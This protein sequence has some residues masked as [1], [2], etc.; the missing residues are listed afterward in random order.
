MKKVK[1]FEAHDNYVLQ[2]SFTS[3]S[4]RLISAGMDNVLR[5]W[6]VPEW[7]LQSTF[8][9]HEKSVNSF[10]INSKETMLVSGSSDNSV[11][12][13]SFP[14]GKILQNLKDRKQVVAAVDISADDS[15]I[16]AGSYG[17]RVTIWD[18]EGKE[19]TGVK[20]GYKNIASVAFSPGNEFLAV[21]GI[22]DHITLLSVPQGQILNTLQGHSIAVV[23]LE[24]FAGEGSLLSLDYEG[25]FLVW[26]P[27]GWNPVSKLMLGEQRVR[28]FA[29]SPSRERIA[30]STESEVLLYSYPDLIFEEILPVGTKVINGM[31][32]SPDGKWFCAGAADK[33]IRVWEMAAS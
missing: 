25:L 5:L 4:R 21:T 26:D 19:I 2:I 31:A 27:E 18:F 29:V 32:F 24:F 13:W 11:K 1:T 28:G 7:R 33:K 10:A 23:Q 17:G 12:A 3:D 14:E 6:S 20:T 16:C 8:T 22:G 30:F 15:M 9:G